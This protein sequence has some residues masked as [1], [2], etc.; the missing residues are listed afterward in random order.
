MKKKQAMKFWCLDYEIS[1]YE[2]KK[3]MYE[4]TS[5]YVGNQGNDSIDSVGI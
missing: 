3:S 5:M 2:T 4:T 1:S